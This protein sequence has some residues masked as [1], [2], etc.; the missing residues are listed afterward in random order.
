MIAYWLSPKLKEQLFQAIE[1]FSEMHD[2]K[3][4]MTRYRK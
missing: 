3:I 4:R 1:A 2:L